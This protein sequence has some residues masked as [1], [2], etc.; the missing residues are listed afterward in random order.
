MATSEQ[1]RGKRRGRYGAGKT[2]EQAAPVDLAAEIDRGAA[3]Y[4]AAIRRKAELADKA[5]SL[6]G[7]ARPPRDWTGPD[8]Q[9]LQLAQL[10]LVMRGLSLIPAALM[11][12]DQLGAASRV[13]R[14]QRKLQYALGLSLRDEQGEPI[15]DEEGQL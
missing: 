5:A 10:D 13:S 9:C 11:T 15:D 7:A 3:R 1:Q 6:S 12:A 4:R 8:A 2:P 14:E